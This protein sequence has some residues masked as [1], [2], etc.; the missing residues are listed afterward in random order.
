MGVIFFFASTPTFWAAYL[1]CCYP[2]KKMFQLVSKE[3]FCSAQM[4]GFLFLSRFEFA[5][6]ISVGFWCDFFSFVFSFVYC[7]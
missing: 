7:F 2:E 4:V 1:S 6:E 5:N 3:E